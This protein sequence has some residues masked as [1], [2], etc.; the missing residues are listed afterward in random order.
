M[1]KRRFE[2]CEGSMKYNVLLRRQEN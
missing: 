2:K 1:T